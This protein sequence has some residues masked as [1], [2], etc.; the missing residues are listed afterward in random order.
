MIIIFFDIWSFF[1][2]PIETWEMMRQQEFG[3][4]SVSGDYEAPPWGDHPAQLTEP[5]TF[6]WVM[7]MVIVM[8][9][10]LTRAYD[11][12]VERMTTS[13]GDVWLAT[14]IP[15]LYQEQDFWG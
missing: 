2:L 10:L 6:P 13:I 15:S 3:I 4:H 8:V 14:Q 9:I 11:R 12:S 5:T 1:S 7:M